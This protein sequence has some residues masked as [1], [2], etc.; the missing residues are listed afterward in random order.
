M[1]E[2]CDVKIF[3]GEILVVIGK[4]VFTENPAIPLKFCPVQMIDG[5]KDSKTQYFV[6]EA[7]LIFRRVNPLSIDGLFILLILL[8]FLDDKQV[9]TL[10]SGPFF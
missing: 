7:W 5:K 6:G 1:W 10:F 4:L 2:F 8:C 9:K 3:L